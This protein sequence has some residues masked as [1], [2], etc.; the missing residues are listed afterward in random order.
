MSGAKGPT[1]FKGRSLV[2]KYWNAEARIVDSDRA[3]FE[4]HLSRLAD[5]VRV[6]SIKTLDMPALLPCDLLL[7][8][9]QMLPTKDFPKWL[10]GLRRRFQTQ[11]KIWIPAVILA[12]VPFDVL[13]ELMADAARDNWYFDILA[14]AHL[15]SL[16]IRV[17]NLLRIHDHLHELGRYAKAVDDVTQRVKALEQELS[18]KIVAGT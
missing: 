18:A 17:A 1:L 8:A 11:D 2:L 16:P 13:S 5:D 10:S 3:S 7:I 6:E 15:E 14:P 4:H 12:E 9:A